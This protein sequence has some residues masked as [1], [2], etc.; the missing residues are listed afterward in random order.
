MF[1]CIG[2]LGCLLVL[3]VLCVG[4]WF[5]KDLWYP[6]VRAM[7]VATP[8][9]KSLSWAPINKDASSAG[10]R[11]AERLGEKSGPVFANLTPAEFAAWQLEPA[12]KI[13]GTSAGNPEVT[14]HGDTLFVR[15]NVAVTELGDPK[16]LGPLA[17]M[18]DG[19]QPVVIGGR[20][21]MQQPGLLGLQ[22]T[23][24]T[25]NELKLPSALIAKVVKRVSVK[26]RTDS[27]APGVIVLPVPKS[28][29]DVRVSN[30]KIVLYKAVP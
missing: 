25:V 13:L 22:V 1:G 18:L 8:P 7:V 30:G 12:M 19:R 9:A 14:V 29:A 6:R 17:T 23:Q 21:A 5:T 27:I 26:E 15:A 20:L 10:T 24:M 28:V 16:S 11:A 3:A 2:R 4:G